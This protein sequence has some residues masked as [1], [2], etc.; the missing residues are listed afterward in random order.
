LRVLFE[1]RG[2][3][4]RWIGFSDN[5]VKVAVDAEGDL[6]NQLLPVRVT[7]LLHTGKTGSSASLLAAG[8][9]L[10]PA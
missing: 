5:Y 9:L 4:G 1:E 8:D 7:G 6:S 10:Q 2:R 3:D